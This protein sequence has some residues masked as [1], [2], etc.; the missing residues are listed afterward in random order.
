MTE[1]EWLACNDAREMILS[2]GRNQENDQQTRY[3]ESW[4][5]R[6]KKAG[7]RRLS[8]STIIYDVPLSFRFLSFL[9]FLSALSFPLRF[10]FWI[11]LV[12][13]Q[14]DGRRGAE[15]NPHVLVDTV[16]HGKWPDDAEPYLASSNL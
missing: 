13:R 6:G 15:H 16:A 5:T 1:A 11:G 14:Q 2:G 4:V 12:H 8:G 10:P 7:H 9:S 3:N